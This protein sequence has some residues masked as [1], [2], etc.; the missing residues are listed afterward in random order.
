MF[1][2]SN[3]AVAVYGLQFSDPTLFSA[4][5]IL[6]FMLSKELPFSSPDR[7]SAAT[8]RKTVKLLGVLKKQKQT[9]PSGWWFWVDWT[10]FFFFPKSSSAKIV[11][12]QKHVFFYKGSQSCATVLRGVIFICNVLPSMSCPVAQEPWICKSSESPKKPGI[13]GYKLYI[14]IWYMVES[15]RQ[16][17]E[18]H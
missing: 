18:I 14:Y 11:N 9:P 8:M 13:L 7:D 6:F 16:W 5:V 1:F 4:G 17:Y 10:C 3:H 15:T 2:L 12:Q